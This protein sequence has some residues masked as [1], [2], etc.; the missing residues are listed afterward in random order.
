MKTTMFLMLLG[1]L[2]IALKLTGFIAWSWWLI[3]L[4]IYATPLWALGWVLGAAILF[5]IVKRKPTDG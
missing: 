5:W 4:P 3:L 1:L 2:F